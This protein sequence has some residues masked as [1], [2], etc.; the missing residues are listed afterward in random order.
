MTE[1]IPHFM[2]PLYNT[3]KY[4]LTSSF[5]NSAESMHVLN[6]PDTKMV[7]PMR[8]GDIMDNVDSSGTLTTIASYFTLPPNS[9]LTV[10]MNATKRHASRESQPSDASRGREMPSVRITV[11][12]SNSENEN[13]QAQ[14]D[15]ALLSSP[16]LVTMPFPD[17]SMPFN[18]ITLV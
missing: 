2:M 7:G 1:A 10:C 14:K 13:C 4:H 18:V 6:R 16:S 9:V 15:L 11:K 3:Y 17:A 12:I 8:L 5:N